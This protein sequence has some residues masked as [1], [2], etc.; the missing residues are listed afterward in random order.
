MTG[1]ATA[2][3]IAEMQTHCARADTKAS[4][5]LA[6]AGAAGL[7]LGNPLDATAPLA[8]I[9]GTATAAALLLTIILLFTA[10]RPSTHGKFT[11]D[12]L[13][14]GDPHEHL[15]ALCNLT[16]RKY[17]L[18]RHAVDTLYG[19]IGFAALTVLTT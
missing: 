3:C 9:A 7:A 15:T 5:L 1:T 8:R 12:R 14:N 4:L 6:L 17:R 10:V 18:I 19:A 2:A 16:N 13:L 11:A